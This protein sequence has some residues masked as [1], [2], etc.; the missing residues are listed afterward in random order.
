[1]KKNFNIKIFIFLI[2]LTFS[3]VLTACTEQPVTIDSL[4]ND[5]GVVI[6]GG[7][8]EEGS[9]LITNSVT[10][11]SNEGKEVLDII[12]SQEYNKD[13]NIY[14]FDI[15]VTKENK[16]IQPKGKVE[17]SIPISLV[18]GKEYLVFHI[19]EDNSIE[20][21]IPTFLDG[22]VTF[23]VSSFS[24]FA[25]V[26]EAIEV[27]THNYE[28]VEGVEPSCT[29]EGKVK[30]YHCNECGKNFDMNYGEI[31]DL[32]I[33]KLNH[34]YSSMYWGKSPSF[35]EDGNIE[36]YQ[37]EECE[38]YFDVDYKEVE[39]V[40]LPKLS[41]NISIC[42]NGVATPLVI[43]EEQESHIIWTLDGLDVTEGDAITICE[44]DNPSAIYNYFAEGNVSKDGV[45]ISTAENVIVQ[46]TATPNGI[47]LFI[48][49]YKYEGIVI[50]INGEQ[51]PMASVTYQDG[52]PTYI[53]GYVYLNQ[54]D[55]FVIIDNENDITYDY[56]DL[57]DT[58]LWNK[59]D[60]HRGDDGEFVI[61]FSARYG[62][63]FDDGG[64]KQIYLDKV[65]A[66]VD[67]N[68]FEIVF[69]DE[70]IDSAPL[71]EIKISSSDEMY[72][73][74]LWELSNEEVMNKEDIVSYIKE[75]EIYV[76]TDTIYLEE[77]VKFNL[78][79]VS[80]DTLIGFDR[81]TDVYTSTENFTKDGNY[82]KVLNSGYYM[83][84]Y[85]PC[86]DSFMFTN[87]Y[88]DETADLFMYIDGEFIP[89]TI[90]EDNIVTYEDLVVEQ[91]TNITFISNDY[92]EYYPI[93]ID[94]NTD[95]SI[96]QII[97]S[98]GM[99]VVFFNK[100]GT[101]DLKYNVETGVL[102]IIDQNPKEPGTSV[103]YMYFLSVVNNANGNQTLYFTR[104]PDENKE[105][106][107]KEANLSANCYIAVGGV[108]LDGSGSTQNYGALS[109]T[110]S[111]IAV[112]YGT[113]IIVKKTG[114]FDIYFNTE[115]KS[116]RL[117]LVGEA[118]VEPTTPK[119]IY[120]RYDNILTLSDNPDNTDE[121]CYFGLEIGAYETFTIRDTNRNYITD[122]TLAKGIT[123]ASTNGK[124]IAF[125]VG[126]TFNIYINK[127]THEV[128]IVVVE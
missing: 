93:T 8:F 105:V 58:Y 52:T 121:L 99:S 18:E 106:V 96:A 21:L 73:E 45:I 7:E 16:K 62:I 102:T 91:Y 47:M 26:E 51:Y 112:S 33:E 23:E 19:K 97:E 128:R 30:H 53:Y 103:E 64:N 81:L 5:Y 123:N 114:K 86:I 17:V 12:S 41:T 56:D 2:I 61:D 20:K 92:L 36:Y 118:E 84:S 77:G 80:K 32:T 63:E 3:F 95:S 109:N 127:T 98:E 76:Y 107:I 15:Y 100:E 44:T 59:W 87:P 42:V 39:S 38:K 125:Q 46:A 50:E 75:H 66:P 65:F 82:I 124:D 60:F 25:I 35:W 22:K 120:I 89:L 85:M 49:G 72:K 69:E 29:K 40:I 43:V 94:S 4:K 10:I 122:L 83:I 57:Y 119:D 111:S 71:T 27:H 31:E 104:T 6:E 117:V 28:F 37:C 79:N 13:G 110:D 116:A 11:D 34:D 115:T 78:R 74:Y 9:T 1:M 113:L 67:G 126:G 24:Y 101:Y 68:S 108:A 54:G 55:E 88:T 48:D 90:N 70:S 14:I